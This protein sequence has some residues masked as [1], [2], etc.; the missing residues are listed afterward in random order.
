MKE[1]KEEKKVKMVKGRMKAIATGF[2]GMAVRKKDDVFE[3]EGPQGSW[4]EPVDAKEAV[5]NDV[6]AANY[7]QMHPEEIQ[8]EAVKPAHAKPKHK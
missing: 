4:F 8:H 5:H 3:F 2:D 6:T 1:E 7:G